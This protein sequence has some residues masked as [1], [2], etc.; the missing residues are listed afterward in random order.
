M[1]SEG[2]EGAVP[3]D[4]AEGAE[5]SAS[6]VEPATENKIEPQ[7]VETPGEGGASTFTEALMGGDDE[8]NA[9]QKPSTGG[10]GAWS[11]I[12]RQD[13][14]RRTTWDVS[15]CGRFIVWLVFIATIV[16]VTFVVPYLLNGLDFS[17]NRSSA[18]GAIGT[19][20]DYQP[21]IPHEETPNEASENKPSTMGTSTDANPSQSRMDSVKS[22]ILQNDVTSEATL[23]DETSNAH[24]ALQWISEVD[25]AQVEPL[26]NY[27]DNT[28]LLQRYAL[29]VLYYSTH[30]TANANEHSQGIAMSDSSSSYSS[31]EEA[32]KLPPISDTEIKEEV[33]ATTATSTSAPTAAPQ[34]QLL[35][36]KPEPQ[37]EPEPKEQ[38]PQEVHLSGHE[39]AQQSDK[40]ET[41][42][43]HLSLAERDGETVA[44]VVAHVS[45]HDRDG[46]SSNGF[47]EVK[48]ER[49]NAERVR[50][51][52][53][54]GG[55]LVEDKWMTASH[56]CDWYGIECEKSGPH[57]VVT[58]VKLESN[59][60]R[61]NLP[62]ELQALSKL[63]VFN[64]SSNELNGQLPATLWKTLPSIEVFAVSQNQFS[65]SIY[66]SI[67]HLSNL[68]D[69]DLSSNALTGKIPSEMAKLGQLKSIRLE[70]NV[71]K[72]PIPSLA[73]LRNLSKN[74][75]MV[76]QFWGFSQW[77]TFC[78]LLVLVGV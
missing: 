45:R 8:K 40:N 76:K 2:K 56:V 61:G 60:L 43:T 16:L 6:H 35:D 22:V 70:N 38:M 51:R 4:G 15:F 59:G 66:S 31:K 49:H 72:G 14:A 23:K 7:G 54:G 12:P 73:D 68:Q 34:I 25:P 18:A 50:S 39:E 69:L 29:A 37:Q 42:A 62:S 27:H 32:G 11:N 64:V 9:P 44:A 78:T 20:A 58:S 71:L 19:G 77:L 36:V 13:K 21:S 48:V 52:N 46:E 47:V 26:V 57:Q 1:T 17:G 41:A 65:G 33:L 55:W 3:G 53:L 63:V 24:Y 30:P 74:H 10:D 28:E 5:S 75:H 67:D